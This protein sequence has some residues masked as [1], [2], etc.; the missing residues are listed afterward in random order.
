MNK[1]RILLADDHA[2]VR[3]GLS[4]LLGFQRDFAVVGEA[5]DGR[6]A[7]RKAAEL[8]PDV[9]LLDLM[10]PELDGADATREILKACPATR[11]LLLTTF[12]DSADL[13]RAFENGAQGAITKDLP[14]ERIFD[15]IR[16]TAEGEC[17]LSPEI[18]QSLQ[19]EG[20][21]NAVSDRQ[22]DILDGL[23]RGLTNRD[24]ACQLGL[25]EAGVKF[26]LLKIFRLLGAANRSEATAIALRRHLLKSR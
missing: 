5:V 8:T 16:K 1:I 22:R 21:L 18:E 4:L 9:V 24:I 25:S 7:V 6:D 19:E 17:V 2:I 12:G 11:I 3:E 26:H 23:A 20:G 13:N 10:M 15:A 14:K